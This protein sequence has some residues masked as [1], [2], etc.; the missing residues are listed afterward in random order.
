MVEWLRYLSHLSWRYNAEIVYVYIKV[1]N[2]SI[3]PEDEVGRVVL[4]WLNEKLVVK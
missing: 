1:I 3:F 2:F 4:K